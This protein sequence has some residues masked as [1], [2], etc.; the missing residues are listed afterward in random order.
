MTDDNDLLINNHFEHLFRNLLPVGAHIPDEDELDCTINIDYDQTQ[1]QT[2][3]QPTINH[4]NPIIKTSPFTKPTKIPH[5][6]PIFTPLTKIPQDEFSNIVSFQEELNNDSN[7]SSKSVDIS[8]PIVETNKTHN[9]NKNVCNR[10][11][12]GIRIRE[13]EC[14]IVCDSRYCINCLLKA[15]G[16]M[17]EGRKCVGCIGKPINEFKRNRLGKCSRMLSKVCNDKLEVTQIL[18]AEK[19]SFV[20]Q[21]NPNQIVVNS[22]HLKPEDLVELLGCSVPPLKLKPGRYWYDKDSGLWG[23]VF[24]FFFH[25]TEF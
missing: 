20:N 18:M 14:C 23:Q 11:G 13:K 3:H 1:T 17:P 19:E 21:I 8:I 24:D 9:K 10:C 5:N 25:D 22:S 6:F 12:K 15:M 7:I 2:H 4:S 16:S